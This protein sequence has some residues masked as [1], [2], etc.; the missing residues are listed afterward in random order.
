M[1]PKAVRGQAGKGSQVTG[2]KEFAGDL[3]RGGGEDENQILVYLGANGML[4]Q[5]ENVQLFLEVGLC[6]EIRLQNW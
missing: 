4:G 3:G 5:C 2:N 1:V 6:K